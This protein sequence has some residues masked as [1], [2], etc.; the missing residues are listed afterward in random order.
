MT[1]RQMPFRN[2]NSHPAIRNKKKKS[3]IPSQQK[4][5]NSSSQ[6]SHDTFVS[7]RALLAPLRTNSTKHLPA[8][9]HPLRTAGPLPLPTKYLQPLYHITASHP[10]IPLS[11]VTPTRPTQFPFK[12]LHAIFCQ[13]SFAGHLLPAIFCILS[14]N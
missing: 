12:F 2:V 5:V 8:L 11:Q 6:L 9:S 10:I 3:K 14:L 7:S 4:A 1:S 13:P